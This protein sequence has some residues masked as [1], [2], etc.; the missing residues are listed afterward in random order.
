MKKSIVILCM[1]LVSIHST[2]AYELSSKDK[3]SLEKA[4]TLLWQLSEKKDIVWFEERLKKIDKLLPQV[5]S[6]IRFWFIFQELKNELL[7]ISEL[8]KPKMEKNNSQFE[9]DFFETYG[10]NIV[11]K[12]KLRDGCTKHFDFVDEIAQK[13]DFPTA[14]IL[15]VWSKE[16]N[17]I[18]ANPANGW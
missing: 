5:K 16:F 6:N 12:N 7:L 18:L 11:Y 9:R 4:K 10:K 2:F 14:L 15:A 13:N 8:K 3:A 17:C 1:L